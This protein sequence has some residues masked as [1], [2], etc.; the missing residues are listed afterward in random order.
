MIKIYEKIWL[1]DNSFENSFVLFLYDVKVFFLKNWLCIIV[2]FFYYSNIRS[3][4]KL[5]KFNC[6]F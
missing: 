4:V 5:D 2:F 1:I 6:I 3:L